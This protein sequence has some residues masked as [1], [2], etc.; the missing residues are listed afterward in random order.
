MPGEDSPL[1]ENSG[2]AFRYHGHEVTYDA[3]R[4][5]NLTSMWEASGAPVNR[6]PTQWK[7]TPQA[8]S[9]IRDLAKSENVA[10]SHVF[11]S[12]RGRGNKGVWSHWQVA[13]AYAK[14]LS[15]DFHRFVNEAFREWAEEKAN[16][17]LKMDRAIE[18][19][20]QRG[21]SDE[22]ISARF[23]GVLNRHKLTDTLKEHG[24]LGAGY[25]ICT[26]AINKPI[27][28][29]GAK[30]AKLA[31]GLKPTAN[32]RDNLS[33]VELSALDFAETMARQKIRDCQAHG[34]GECCAECGKAGEVVRRAM[35]S[36]GLAG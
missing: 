3:D 25:A 27:L 2:I 16:P 23:R 29:G 28:G 32:L 15:N 19:H 12:M 8:L 20:R 14:Y 1:R 18:G 9:F 31:R 13:L 17:D 33:P 34:N 22:W 11:R 36:M 24:V 21:R 35:E 4:F 26:D 7:K 30:E 5:I 10:I 6:D